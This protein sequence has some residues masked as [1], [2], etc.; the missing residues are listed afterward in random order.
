M[1]SGQPWSVKGIDPKAREAAKD[2][3]RRSGMTL[4]EWLNQVILEDE[5]PENSASP[6]ALAPTPE[7]A[8]APAKPVYRRAELPTHS[9]DEIVRMGEALDELASR[10]ETAENRTAE[11]VGGVD[12]TVSA[13]VARL[14]G[15][16]RENT[17]I[18]ARFE[19]LAEEIRADQIRLADRLQRAEQHA[20]EPG[21][22]EALH[23]MEGAVAKVAGHLYESE[24]QTRDALASLRD[25]LDGVSARLQQAPEDNAALIETMVARIAERLDQAEA[26]TTSAIHGLEASFGHLESRLGAAEN[27]LAE[28]AQ[29]V[30]LEQI[31]AQLSADVEAVRTDM[32]EKIQAAAEGRLDRV[33]QALEEISGHVKAA[34]RRST[35]ALERMGHEVLRLAD[36]FGR[37]VQ[38][39]ERRSA[40]AIEQ[41]GGDVARIADT[42]EARLG[43]A[44]TASAQ[45]LEKLGGEIARITERLA[46]RIGNAERRSAQ[47]IDDVGDQV[48]RVTARL[49]ERQE[50]T[51]SDLADRIRQS[52]ERTARLLEDAR[53]RVDQR[54]VEAPMTPA[55][56]SAPE[57]WTAPVLEAHEAEAPNP[58]AHPRD[59]VETRAFDEPAFSEPASSWHA[60]PEPVKFGFD[61]PADTHDEDALEYVAAE[62]E[63]AIFE[64]EA[65]ETAPDLAERAFTPTVFSQSAFE[66]SAFDEPEP[67]DRE[68]DLVEPAPMNFVA[69]RFQEPGPMTFRTHEFD[70]ALAEP[71]AEA[72]D[73]FLADPFDLETDRAEAEAEPLGAEHHAAEASEDETF[74]HEAYSPSAFAPRTFEHDRFEPEPARAHDAFDEPEEVFEDDPFEETHQHAEPA[75][76]AS[77]PLI[78][79]QPLTGE[80]PFEASFDEPLP[81][82]QAAA[83]DPAASHRAMSTRE[84]IEQARAAAR[85]AAL[86]ADP[87]ARKAAARGESSGIGFGGLNLSLSKKPKRRNP[88]SMGAA[89]MVSGTAAVL[90]VGAAGVM[91]FAG[92]PSGVLSP[93]VMAA[94][95]LQS[96]HNAIQP[97][98]T[99]PSEAATADPMAAVALAPQPSADE[100]DAQAGAGPAPAA[101]AGDSGA[102]LYGDAV[103]RIE[104]RDF[105]GLDGL[106]KAANLGYAPAEFY[107]AKLYETG[108]AS[109][110]KDLGEARRW[111]ERAAEAGDRKAMHNLALY[112]V[113]GSGGPKNTTTAAQWFRRAADLGLVDSQYNLGRL[114]EEGFGV[115]QNPAEAYKWYLIAAHAGDAESRASAQRLKGQLSAEAQ[116]A[117]ERAAGAFQAQNSQPAATQLAQATTGDVA[118]AAIAQRALSRLGYYQ[119]PTDGSPSPALKLAIEAYQ[120][121][122]GLPA[123]GIPDSALSQRLAVIAQ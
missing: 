105:S 40:I 56:H 68:P 98:K 15:S 85:A 8:V 34:E 1:T 107:L 38:D 71:D 37:K 83:E 81:F 92:H 99:A 17:V 76:F 28:Q 13:L 96:P 22:A 57:S 33:E 42:M 101:T 94:L 72:E 20:D 50:R 79:E 103:R 23:A 109:L 108:E 53:L 24:A 80:R 112:Y 10:V 110:K 86:A 19:G 87:K 89:L 41:V 49:Q 39:V 69:Q 111:T 100:A 29:G 58:F 115:T 64:A 36:A 2:L 12:Q 116:A 63:A 6:A 46:D 97:A 90:G 55:A 27:V 62:P 118:G 47:A 78:A 73:P 91:L 52:E 30:G 119:G 59:E 70:A 82:G 67:H 21:S 95:G 77:P 61:A 88:S 25:D 106:R 11:M 84:L 45:A 117:A 122:Q 44:D 14:D 9:Q 35:D 65:E 31:A 114:Y 75:S 26:R 113:E 60:E 121:D 74:E 120:R 66:Q 16:E 7:P 4:G 32:A 93:R 5:A 43:Q 48:A 51:A 3:A 104:A 123:T 54:P 102:E 18:A